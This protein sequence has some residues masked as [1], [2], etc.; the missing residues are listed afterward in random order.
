MWE[1]S[2]ALAEPH[3]YFRLA[4]AHGCGVFIFIMNVQHTPGLCYML[5]G[6][7]WGVLR[8]DIVTRRN[9]D[10]ESQSDA[11]RKQC[12]ARGCGQVCG[13]QTS[14]GATKLL[15]SRGIYSGRQMATMSVFM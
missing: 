2:A 14:L 1:E 5:L 6:M 13:E 15:W 11:G 8:T 9:A 12:D 4:A 3:R 10:L 7:Q